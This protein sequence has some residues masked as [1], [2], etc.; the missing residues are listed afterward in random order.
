MDLRFYKGATWIPRIQKKKIIILI[1]WNY[2]GNWDGTE[3][4]LDQAFLPTQPQSKFYRNLRGLFEGWIYDVTALQDA[5][6]TLKVIEVQN[7]R[8]K[9]WKLIGLKGEKSRWFFQ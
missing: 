9:Q 3:E 7:E 4:A 1:Q 6:R 5:L 8:E 2:S